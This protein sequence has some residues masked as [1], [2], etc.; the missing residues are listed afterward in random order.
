MYALLDV[1]GPA[2]LRVSKVHI[3]AHLRQHRHDRSVARAPPP[4]VLG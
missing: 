3:R 4:T 1:K 2:M